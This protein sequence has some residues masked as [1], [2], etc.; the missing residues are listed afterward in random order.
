M[1]RVEK[2]LGLPPLAKVAETLQKFPDVKQ[3]QLIE[4]VLIIAERISRAGPQLGQVID[5][6]REINSMPTEKLEKLERVLRRIEGIIKKA[7]QELVSFLAS[8]KEE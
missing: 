6:I 3:L 7:P 4:K 1:E 8:L 2:V 5:I